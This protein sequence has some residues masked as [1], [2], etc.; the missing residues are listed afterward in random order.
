MKTLIGLSAALVLTSVSLAEPASAQARERVIEVSTVTVGGPPVPRQAPFYRPGPP[1]QVHHR[2][3]HGP[4]PHARSNHRSVRPDPRRE[5]ARM[6]NWYASQA[7]AQAREGWRL[8]CARN[9]PRW[10]TSYQ[11][12]YRWAYGATRQQVMREIERRDRTLAQCWAN[13]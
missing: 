5:Q 9:H 13:R 6:A 11:E 8:G 2:H 4:P 10:S 7:V 3:R 1:P 12:H